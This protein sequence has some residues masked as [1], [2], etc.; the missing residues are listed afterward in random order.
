MGGFAVYTT[1]KDY[2]VYLIKLGE[3]VKYVGETS[4]FERRKREHLKRVGDT[5]HS[6]IPVG[7][8]LSEI[9]IIKV[10]DFS[11]REEALKC[12]GE[13]ILQYDTINNGWNKVRSGHLSADGKKA[14]MKKWNEE[15]KEER[16]AKKKKYAE[17]HCDEIKAYQKKYREEHKDELLAYGKKYREENKE[18]L[19]AY[20]RERNKKRKLSKEENI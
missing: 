6:A 4:D 20:D 2:T 16:K 7:L 10:K 3:V 5:T 18:R 9:T 17:E 11:D 8:D 19:N 12:E 13:L 1:M 15:N 14:Y